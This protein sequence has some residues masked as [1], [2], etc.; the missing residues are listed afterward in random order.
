MFYIG[1]QDTKA[2]YIQY[3]IALV[4]AWASIVTAASLLGALAVI[5]RQL[6]FGLRAMRVG[7]LA[8]WIAAIGC[9]AVLVRT[10][11]EVTLPDQA[12]IGG[13]SLVAAFIN[14][15]TQTLRTTEDVVTVLLWVGV[16]LG[17]LVL[18]HRLSAPS[19]R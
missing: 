1:L 13:E 7:T 3:A 18:R 8:S 4:M 17:A 10:A 6:G 15:V 9:G 16:W 5:G 14:Q 19:T 11:K 12:L 2:I